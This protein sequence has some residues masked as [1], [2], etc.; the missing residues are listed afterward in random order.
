MSH[1]LQ[2]MDGALSQTDDVLIFGKDEAEHD[3][4]VTAVL[5]RIQDAEATL[6]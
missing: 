1:I 2:G 5:D 6:N 3:T 4:R